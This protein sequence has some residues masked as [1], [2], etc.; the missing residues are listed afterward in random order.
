MRPPKQTL[1]PLESHPSSTTAGQRPSRRTRPGPYAIVNRVSLTRL[2]RLALIRGVAALLLTLTAIDLA[3][4]QLCELDAI[5][6]LADLNEGMGADTGRMPQPSSPTHFDD[7]FCCSHCV[8]VSLM[9]PALVAMP[10]I[11]PVLPSPVTHPLAA[12]RALFHPPRRS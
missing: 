1:Y 2:R 12:A 7:C 8:D 9:Q 10:F 6:V 5:P 3:A 11:S 4:S